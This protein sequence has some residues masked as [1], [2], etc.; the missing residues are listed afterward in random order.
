MT[1]SRPTTQN[2]ARSSPRSPHQ[3]L[4]SLSSHAHSPTSLTQNTFT[5][6]TDTAAEEADSYMAMIDKAVVGVPP[7]QRSTCPH[8]GPILGLGPTV[9]HYEQQPHTT[10]GRYMSEGVGEQH[11]L[12]VCQN[13][14]TLSSLKGCTCGQELE[15]AYQKSRSNTQGA[16]HSITQQS[17]NLPTHRLHDRFPGF[18]VTP[19][20]YKL[21]GGAVP[22]PRWI[23]VFRLLQ[24]I[25]AVLVIALTS[26]SISINKGGPLRP[27]IIAVLIIAIL[28]I[29]PILLF[30]TPLHLSQR[31]LYDPRIALFGEGI[32]TLWWL[33][34]FAALATYQRIFH[35]Y[36][37]FYQ[38]FKRDE[39]VLEERAVYYDGWRCDGGRCR[40]A[41]KTGT[42]ATVFAA[43][44]FLL[45]FLT[46]VLFLYYY[47][48]HMAGVPVSGISGH[49]KGG[50]EAGAVGAGVGA[51]AGTHHENHAMNEMPATTGPTGVGAG[52]GVTGHHNGQSMGQYNGPSATGTNGSGVVGN[53]GDYGRHSD[54]PHPD[55]PPREGA[56]GGMQE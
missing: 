15:A 48:A 36:A 21:K 23:L 35:N 53:A 50:L 34:A 13:G 18:Q 33:G 9:E 29:F 41:W 49:H 27:G 54:I 22:L 10:I 20:M 38:N 2:G 1:S 12:F 55:R 32:A 45:F 7:A 39:G 37:Y 17:R 24:L 4:R 3:Q 26:Y 51:G 6:G 31:R 47:H 19:A 11:A 52:N 42:A 40:R 43:F 8:H 25:F 44:E 14:S 28:T 16:T 30:T 5:N 56:Y 46:T